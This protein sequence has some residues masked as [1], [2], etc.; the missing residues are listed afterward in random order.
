MINYEASTILGL[1]VSRVCVCVRNDT[2]PGKLKQL[3]QH[4]NDKLPQKAATKSYATN[5]QPNLDPHSKGPYIHSTKFIQQVKMGQ[6][7]L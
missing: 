4:A 5:D 6:D 1:V 3:Q 2:V 7:V